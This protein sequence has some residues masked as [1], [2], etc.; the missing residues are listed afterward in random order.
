MSL[1]LSIET[2][3]PICSVALLNQGEILGSQNLYIEKSHS[4]LLAPIIDALVKQCGYKLSDLDAVAVSGGPG[5]YTGLRIGVSTAKGISFSLDIP[6]ISINTL[7]AMAYGMN[8]VN[9]TNALLCPMIDARR[10]EVYCMV[11]DNSLSQIQETAPK[12]VDELSFVEL[13]NER[14]IIFAGNGAGKCRTAIT[15]ENASFIDLP[16]MNAEYVGKLA[17]EKFQEQI[18]EDVAYYEPFYLKEFRVTQPKKR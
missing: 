18:F 1:I 16:F 11:A 8:Q 2:A 15:H 7:E 10:M 17:F 14:E 13:L 3:T 5:S 4:G 9:Y 6:L 12:I